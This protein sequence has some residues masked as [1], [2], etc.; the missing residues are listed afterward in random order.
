[1]TVRATGCLVATLLATLL[2]ASPARAQCGSPNLIANCSFEVDMAGWLPTFVQS[3]T[4]TTADAHTGVASAEAVPAVNGGFHV[5]V[6]TCVAI[7]PGIYGV[8]GYFR[9]TFD[10][11]NPDPSCRVQI[12]FLDA[13]NCAGNILGTTST[14]SRLAADEGWIRV[15]S[16]LTIPAG[17]QGVAVSP[18]CTSGGEYVVRIDDVSIA[19]ADLFDDGFETADTTAWSFATP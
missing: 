11:I 12:V 4:R 7:T 15:H 8:G 18:F 14:E 13:P 5:Q 10:P 3:F 16:S 19:I 9:K 1:M 2:A 6:T 17:T